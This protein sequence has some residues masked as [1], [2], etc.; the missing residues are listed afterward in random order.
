[1]TFNAWYGLV[2]DLAPDRRGVASLATERLRTLGRNL[3]SAGMAC[4]SFKAGLKF[5]DAAAIGL[6]QGVWW[7]GCGREMPR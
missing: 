7:P 2:W 5:C 3:A 1:M 6:W 4:A